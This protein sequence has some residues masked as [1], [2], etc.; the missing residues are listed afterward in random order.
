MD[1]KILVATHKKYDMPKDNMYIPLH[2]G[3]Q[4]KQKLGYMGDN[5]GDNISDKNPNYCELTGLYWAYKNLKCQ[6]IGLCHYRRYFTLKSPWKRFF[7]RNNKLSFI[8]NKSETESLLENYDIILPRKRHYYIETVRSHYDNAHNGSDLEKIYNILKSDYPE[9]VESYNRIMD[10]GSLHLYN[11]FVMKKENFD[12][13]CSWLF[14][15]LFKLE[16]NIDLSTYDEYQSRVFGF[17]SERLFNVW[18][19]Y[20]SMNYAEI[21]ILN[22]ERVHWVKKIIAFLKRKFANKLKKE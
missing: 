4:G 17:L 13:Y 21:P 5:T 8:L 20:K 1:I 9:Y 7:H 14:H 11:M 10:G 18:L 15:I 2:V 12:E 22:M 6:Y 3:C 19:D 16:K